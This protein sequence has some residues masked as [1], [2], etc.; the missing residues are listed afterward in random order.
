MATR[1]WRW[2]RVRIVGLLNAD[3]RIARHFQPDPTPQH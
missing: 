3:T 1:S 2:L